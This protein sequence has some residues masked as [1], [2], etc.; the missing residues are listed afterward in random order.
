MAVT[1][2]LFDLALREMRLGNLDR[3]RASFRQAREQVVREGWGGL[4][5]SIC[6]VGAALVSAEGDHRQAAVLVGVAHT[7][8]LKSGQAPDP[9]EVVEIARVSEAAVNALGAQQFAAES[10]RGRRAGPSS[11]VFEI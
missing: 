10:A 7:A 8:F 3:A 2:E 6:V 4:L 9:G 11:I 1:A 5:P